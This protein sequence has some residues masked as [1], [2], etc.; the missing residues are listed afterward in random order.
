[1]DPLQTKPAYLPSFN[2]LALG[3][4]LPYD[5]DAYLYGTRPTLRADLRKRF[6]YYAP[7]GYQTP[8]TPQT[9]VTPRKKTGKADKIFNIAGIAAL[10][11][12]AA[13]VTGAILKKKLPTAKVT[14][15]FQAVGDYLKA[16]PSRIGG[17]FKKTP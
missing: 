17:L 2:D 16:I 15:A 1:M 6:D 9:P 8:Q 13:I 4:I 11:T 12:T 3:G 5:V 10:G 14:K 7:Q